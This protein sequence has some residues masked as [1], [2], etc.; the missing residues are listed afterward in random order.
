MKKLALILTLLLILT[1]CAPDFFNKNDGEEHLFNAKNSDIFPFYCVDN[2]DVL[3]RIE[4]KGAFSVGE[5]VS[6]KSFIKFLKEKDIIIFTTAHYDKKGVTYCTLMAQNGKNAPESI[7][8]NVRLDSV[9]VQSD[10]NLLFIDEKDNLYFRRDGITTRIEGEVAQSEF[11][12]EDTFLFRLKKAVQ[13]D[14]E[15][16]YPIYHATFDYRNFLMN[17]EDIIKADS[18]NGKAYII[19]NKHTVQKRASAKEVADCYVYGDGEILFSVSSALLSQFDEE[20]HIFMIAV[21]EKEST[22]KY[23]LYRVDGAEPVLKCENVISGRYIAQNVFAYEQQTPQEVKTYII[24]HTDSV[25]GYSLGE[26]CSPENIYYVNPYRYLI[27]DGELLTLGENEIEALI[28][29]NIQSVLMTDNALICIKGTSQPYTVNVCTGVSV[30]NKA[31]DVCSRNVIYK[32][33]YLYYFSNDGKELNVV[34][35]WGNST[36]L[37]GNINTSFLCDKG[38]VAV[39]KNDT[40]TLFLASGNGVIDTELKIKRFVMEE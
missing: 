25:Y 3:W 32:E 18:E 16:L 17:G 30:R 27:K 20:S 12:A 11:V 35:P 31:N 10:G 26:N 38:T 40:S 36:A 2:D 8:E 15:T 28:D 29:D 4:N 33:N 5:E 39:L 24:D 21:N 19:K 7:F 14:N 37:I 13:E 23:D 1:G 22:L 9:R 34:D 6:E